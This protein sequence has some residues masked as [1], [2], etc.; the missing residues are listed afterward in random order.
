MRNMTIKEAH[1]WAS[2]FLR[3]HYIDQAPLEAEVLIRNLFQWNRSQLF[4]QWNQPFPIEKWEPLKQWLDQRIHHIPLQYI[5]GEQEFYGRPFSVNPNVLIPRPET[6][7]LLE[8]LIHE[9][10]QIWQDQPITVVDVGTGSGAIAITLALEKPNWHVHTVDISNAALKTAK[11]NAIKLEAQVTF[12]HGDL[13]KPILESKMKVDLI[14]SNPPYIPTKD[15]DDLMPEVKNNE[16][17]LALDG[18]E[19]GLQFYRQIL[20]QAAKVLNRPGLIAFEIGIDQS[21]PIVELLQQKGSKWKLQ[22]EHIK[23]IPDFQDI[24]RIII[25]KIT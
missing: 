2:S 9:A 5:V 20:Q 14:V 10:D 21:E 7:L 17:M 19:D 24:P 8:H 4:L 3:Q 22:I 13:L 23:V 18:G 11:K 15:L 25:A 12:H 6:E 1:S 16:P